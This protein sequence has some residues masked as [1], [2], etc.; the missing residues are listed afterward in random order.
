[1]NTLLAIVHDPIYTGHLTGPFH[2]EQPSRIQAIGYA[3]EKSG[4]AASLPHI[5]PRPASLEEIELCHSKDYIELVQKETAR[6]NPEELPDDGSISLSTGDASICSA[7]FDIARLAAG[8]AI[9]AVDH[10]LHGFSKRVFCAVRP[11]GHHAHQAIGQGFCIFNN[12]AI[13][14]RYA[15]KAYGIEKILIADWDVH[16]GDGTQAIF[17]DDPSVF[18]F[19]THRY[20][21]GFYPGTGAAVETGLGRGAGTTLNCPFIIEHGE[22]P[23]RS[24]LKAFDQLL[25][26]AIK[27]FKPELVLISAGFD[28]HFKDP[29]GG[30]D[31][32][33]AHYAALTESI[34]NIAGIYCQG[35]IVS[36]LEGGYSLSGLASSTIAHLKSLM[37]P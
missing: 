24:I 33:D 13:A 26:Q 37:L 19:S 23:S 17:Y 5:P 21:Y 16:H 22:V 20:G 35:R 8:G 27:S 31:L 28:A 10:V 9:A 36:L 30:C 32:T 34:K 25:A 18:Y 6:I 11:P 4:L 7:S 12:I 1:M 2:P 29:L 3:L 14:A 15:Q